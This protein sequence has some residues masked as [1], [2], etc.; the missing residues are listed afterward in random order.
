MGEPGLWLVGPALL[1]A[2]IPVGLIRPGNLGRLAGETT[3]RGKESPALP[4]LQHLS[5][6][7]ASTESHLPAAVPAPCRPLQ[8]PGGFQQGQ[9][10]QPGHTRC[11]RSSSSAGQA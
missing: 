5:L 1:A 8:A 9:G 6:L 4:S 11:S 3:L 10:E 2:V 7:L